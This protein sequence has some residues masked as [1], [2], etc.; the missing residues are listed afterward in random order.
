MSDGKTNRIKWTHLPFNL[1]GLVE[2]A[3]DVREP[4]GTSK[5]VQEPGTDS[6]VSAA[7]SASKG[8]LLED[9]GPR[10]RDGTVFLVPGTP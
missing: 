5:G 10:R 9:P 4:E 3:L 7:G 1:F 2:A 6:E 8:T